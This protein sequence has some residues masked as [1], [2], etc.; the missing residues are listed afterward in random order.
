MR[1]LLTFL[2]LIASVSAC[3][4]SGRDAF[5]PV[6]TVQTLEVPRANPGASFSVMVRLDVRN[7][8]SD[9]ITIQRVE[10]ASAG[11]GAFDVA[12]AT[13]D[14]DVLVPSSGNRIIEVWAQ[15]A[16][17][18]S[19]IGGQ[20]GAVLLRGAI[21]Y[22]AFAGARRVVFASRVPTTINQTGSQ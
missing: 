22:E 17:G 8:S 12:P 16:P 10:L 20:E 11:I 19:D 13:R 4:S 6:V 3:V 7:P 5:A 18:Q 2:I 1:I 9:P 21:Y 14:F 15:A